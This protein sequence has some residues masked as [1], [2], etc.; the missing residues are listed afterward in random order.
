MAEEVARKR[1]DQVLV[2][3]LDGEELVGVCTA[4]LDHSPQLSTAMWHVRVF[5]RADARGALT[6]LGLVVAGREELERRWLAGDRRAPGALLVVTRAILPYMAPNAWWIPHD[7]W[8]IGENVRGDHLR[9]HWFP[10]APAP[11]LP[12]PAAAK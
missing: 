2:V 7:F 8:F 11:A 1:L 12:F 4:Y 3:A 10:G 9:V 5:V 6:G